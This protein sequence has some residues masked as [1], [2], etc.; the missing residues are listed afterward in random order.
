MNDERGTDS[1]LD[2]RLWN[3][4]LL[5][6]GAWLKKTFPNPSRRSKHHSKQ[7]RFEGSFRQKRANLL[8]EVLARPNQSAAELA[9]SC[10]FELT[11]TE[12]ALDALQVEGFLTKDEHERYSIR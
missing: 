2:A 5:D 4:A 7:S 9:I 8:R 6:Y 3:Y 10:D 12:Q 1:T 11:D